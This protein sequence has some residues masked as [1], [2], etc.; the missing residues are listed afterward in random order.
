MKKT[1][2][3]PEMKCHKLRG[4]R[5]LAG[6]PIGCVRTQ[7][8][9]CNPHCYFNCLKDQPEGCDPNCNYHCQPIEWNI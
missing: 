3:K 1:F 8:D 2:V 4:D 9:N 5:I 6:S 7:Q